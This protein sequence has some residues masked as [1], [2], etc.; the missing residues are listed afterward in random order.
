MK[1]LSRLLPITL[2]LTW[3]ATATA[4]CSGGC[5]P[6]LGSHLDRVAVA[7]AVNAHVDD[8]VNVY[9]LWPIMSD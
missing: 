3:T 9:D 4:T 2:T 6:T 8:Q 7:V 5:A 1:F